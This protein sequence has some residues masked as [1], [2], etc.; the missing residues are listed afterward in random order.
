MRNF[1]CKRSMLTRYFS[2]ANLYRDWKKLTFYYFADAYI[3]FNPLVTDLFKIY[4][5][6][7]WMSAINPASFVTPVTGLQ[8][9]T[10][11][12][13][14]AFS[15]DSEHYSDRRQQKSLS[16]FPTLGVPQ[17]GSG[18]F[19]R[20]WDPNRDVAASNGGMS[21]P[22]LYAQPFQS[23]DLDTR[24]LDQYPI[25]YRQAGQQVLGLQP[26]FNSNSYP[27][28]DL[29]H[30]SYAISS[31]NNS[32]GTRKPHALGSEWNNTFQGLSLGS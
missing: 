6:R 12:G 22:H 25:E 20:M 16:T 23:H 29:H 18:S 31:E 28:P 13:P 14:G 15:S 2:N 19:D 30:S 21:F 4:K 17:L 5:T 3:N 27:V 11:L 32:G 7:I 24:H 8:L 9:P 26:R 10:G 1:R